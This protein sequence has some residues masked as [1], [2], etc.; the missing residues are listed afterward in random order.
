LAHPPKLAHH[1]QSVLLR[2][3]KIKNERFSYFVARSVPKRSFFVFIGGFVSFPDYHH[4]LGRAL[5]PS[6]SDTTTRHSAIQNALLALQS[7]SPGSGTS[8]V[9]K[10]TKDFDLAETTLRRAIQNDGHVNRPGRAKILT[11]HEEEQL[12]GYCLNMR[13]LGFG[14]TK[15]EER[16]GCTEAD[17]AR[18]REDAETRG[19]ETQE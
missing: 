9:R 8:S 7:A 2:S 17:C 10:L 16:G 15:S 1:T 18:D 5:M 11:D 14:L 4:S 12:T 3:L 6:Y 13:K 19:R